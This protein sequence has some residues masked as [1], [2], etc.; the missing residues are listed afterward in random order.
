MDTSIY[1]IETWFI[2]F[3]KILNL[4]KKNLFAHLINYNKDERGE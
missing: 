3:D 4:Q 1:P 2:Y